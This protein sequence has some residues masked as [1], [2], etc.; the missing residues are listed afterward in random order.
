[1][2]SMSM[3]P[4]TESLMFLTITNVEL[5]CLDVSASDSDEAWEVCCSLG[6][7]ATLLGISVSTAAKHCEVLSRLTTL[8]LR[9]CWSARL[10]NT[11]HLSAATTFAR[12][13]RN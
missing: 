13:C 1:M 11:V 7:F 6:L 9:R 10:V 5:I 3:L 2:A 12:Q 8:M 4:S